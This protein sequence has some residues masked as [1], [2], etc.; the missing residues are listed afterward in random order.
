MTKTLKTLA[1][2]LALGAAAMTGCEKSTAEKMKDTGKD[3]ARETADATREAGRKVDDAARDAGRKVDDAGRDVGRKADDAADTARDKLRDAKEAV[4]DAVKAAAD[5][6]KE[7]GNAVA[8][9]AKE[10][11]DAARKAFRGPHDT[12]V[13]KADKEIA[14][15]EEESKKASGDAKKALDEKITK[16]KEL[17]TKLNAKLKDMADAT[18]D[19]WE[20]T[21][22][23]VDQ[24]S[25]DLA[26]S[27]G[28]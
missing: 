27:L 10:A 18:S 4:K 2:G 24:L 23:D 5:K 9:K 11:A 16:S 7:A 12:G 17:R 28:F 25:K 21:K 1:L 26:K 8:D 22:A 14:R 3:A 6:A 20:A 19:K 13:E 15:L